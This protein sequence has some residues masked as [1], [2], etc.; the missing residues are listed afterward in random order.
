MIVDQDCQGTKSLVALLCLAVIAYA[1]PGI[2]E[3]S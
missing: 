3:G 2:M 1:V